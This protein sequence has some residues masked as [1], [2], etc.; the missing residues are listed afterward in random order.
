MFIT[1]GVMEVDL[2][3]LVLIGIFGLLL[4]GMASRGI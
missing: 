2:M 1:F 3:A 4:L